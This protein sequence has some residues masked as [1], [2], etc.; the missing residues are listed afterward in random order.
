M[1]DVNEYW[2]PKQAVQA[3]HEI[4]QRYDITWI[5]EPARRWDYEGLA[6]VSRRIKAAVATAENL[7]SIGGCPLIHNE[8]WISSTF[9]RRRRVL[10]VSAGSEYVLCLRIARIDDELP[11]QLY[12]AFGAALPNHLAM[13]VVDPGRSTVYVLITQLKTG[14]SCWGMRRGSGSKLTR[15]ACA[16][17]RPIHRS[18]RATFP[19]LD[20]RALGYT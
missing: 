18:E 5:E 7:R 14:L 19:L 8:A 1:V 20:V 4:E 11:G 12:G 2:S 16:N 15:K 13:E 17:C 10:R 6:S 3:M 9:R